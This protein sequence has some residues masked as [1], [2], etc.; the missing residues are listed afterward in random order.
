MAHN[1]YSHKGIQPPK[2]KYSFICGKCG[3][4]FTSK[5]ALSGKFLV[6]NKNEYLIIQLLLLLDHERSNCGEKPIYKCEDCGKH[7]HSAGSLKTHQTLHVGVMPHL[8]NYCGKAFRTVG[9]VKVHERSHNGIKPYKCDVSK[10][11]Y[12]YE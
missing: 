1:R 10:N 6:F 4:S 11:Y 12:L 9:Q 8:C 2:K 7:Y 3:K 5:V